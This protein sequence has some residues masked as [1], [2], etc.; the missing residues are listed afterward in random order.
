MTEQTSTLRDVLKDAPHDD[1]VRTL[2][3]VDSIVCSPTLSDEVKLQSIA[4]ALS[5]DEEYF[6]DTRS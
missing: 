1:L 3:W 4:I 5:S 6:E 2:V